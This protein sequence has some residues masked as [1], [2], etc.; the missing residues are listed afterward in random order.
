M[1][2]WSW[3]FASCGVLAACGGHVVLDPMS[4]AGT[5]TGGSTSTSATSTGATCP[6]YSS[7]GCCPGDG[8]CCDCVSGTVC[9]GGPFDPVTP[10]EAAFDDCVCQASVCGA[11]CAAACAGSGIDQGCPAC[12]AQA[13][14]EACAA[15]F[16]QCPAACSA[17]PIC[18]SGLTYMNPQ[19]GDCLGAA[20]CA[21][22]SACDVDET[23]VGCFYGDMA[24]GCDVNA[25]FMAGEAC[26]MQMCA[27][28][29]N[30]MSPCGSAG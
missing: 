24:A 6:S 7:P 11:Q 29:C 15:Q 9:A 17:F 21:E 19:C 20:C 10:P 27:S 8:D 12:A 14:M 23:C 26:L 18:G 1:K 16:A 28:E 13:A 2:T 22:F 25:T 3:F 4:G 5:G 30:D